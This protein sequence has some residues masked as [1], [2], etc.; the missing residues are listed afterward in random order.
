MGWACKTWR[1]PVLSQQ[2]CSLSRYTWALERCPL[3]LPWLWVPRAST[4]PGTDRVLTKC[5]EHQNIQ[6]SFIPLP[7]L[8]RLS[9]A[10]IKLHFLW[11]FLCWLISGE[12]TRKKK[13]NP[14]KLIVTQVWLALWELEYGKK[15]S[16][17]SPRTWLRE[18]GERFH[19]EPHPLPGLKSCPR[20][21]GKY[22]SPIHVH[23]FFQAHPTWGISEHYYLGAVYQASNES[24]TFGLAGFPSGYL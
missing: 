12:K 6:E 13:K 4:Q 9:S 15:K 16:S 22:P 5:G 14:L 18:R 20:S 2:L 21:P 1:R 17:V 3:C 24:M 7:E 8:T 10:L 19:L 23:F 11:S